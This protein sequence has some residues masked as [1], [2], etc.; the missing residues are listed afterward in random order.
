MPRKLEEKMLYYIDQKIAENG[1]AQEAI[2]KKDPR[3]L[4]VVVAQSL[5][6]IRESGGNN[7]GPM[8]ELIQETVGQADREPWCMSFVQTCIAYCEVKT[9][10]KSPILASEHCMTVWRNTDPKQRVK[11]TPMAGAIAIWKKGNTDSGHTGIVLSCD[12]VNMTLIEGNTEAGVAKG[13]VVRDGGGVYYTTRSRV[14][15]GNMRVQGWLK[16]F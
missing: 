13:K 15:S 7:K 2:K 14:R 5:N 6:G 16:P 12:E 11:Y 4:L 8:V 10:I 1:L 9:G 3:T